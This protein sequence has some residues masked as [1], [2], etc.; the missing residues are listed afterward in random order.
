MPN[1]LALLS[2]PLE[3]VDVLVIGAGLA[4]LSCAYALKQAGLAVQVLE[5]SDRLGGNIDTRSYEGIVYEYGPNSFMNSSAELMA[6][7]TELGLEPE[8]IETK[9]SESKRYLYKD[10]RLLEVSPL[11]LLFSP[12]LSWGA[13]LR[14]LG[15]PWCPKLSRDE[16]TVYDFMQRKFGTEPAELL[17]SFLRGVWGADSRRLSS[18][19]ALSKLVAMETEHGS[20]LR[21]L[22]SMRKQ[23]RA[24]LATCSFRKG[25]VQ[26]ID[27]LADNI[28]KTS[29]TARFCAVNHECRE[30]GLLRRYAPRNDVKIVLAT[31][32]NE[33]A[34]ILSS[35][36]LDLDRDWALELAW[37]LR[38]INYAPIYLVSLAFSQ[39]LLR[40]PLSGFGFLSHINSGLETLGTIW[41]SELFTERNIPNQHLV[42]SYFSPQLEEDLDLLRSRAIAEQIQVLQ[43]YAKRTL[44]I[45]D[46][47]VV[48]SKYIEAAIPQYELGM[49]EIV[50]AIETKLAKQDQLYLVGNYLH[51][52]SLEDLI[53]RSN[54][55]AKKIVSSSSLVL[56]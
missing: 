7:V 47:T 3:E 30:D 12:L 42:T 22:L 8:L 13:K 26:L 20:I 17:A 45:A 48:D 18:R 54:A 44:T 50:A 41:S 9:F 1:L 16:E 43:P 10:S 38:Q 15:E 46:F 19:A 25:M 56:Q 34:D 33:A 36:L 53:K 5:K 55:V 31:K 29:L 23:P 39:D 14:I 40:K 21:A 6:L 49:P 24:S 35:G 32:A 2:M 37:L 51:G 11:S 52:I 27:A 4:G 28:A